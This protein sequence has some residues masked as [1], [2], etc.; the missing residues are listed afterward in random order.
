[1]TTPWT[2]A[3][4]GIYRAVTAAK[5]AMAGVRM[6]VCAF[7][8]VA[9]RGPARVPRTRESLHA[10]PPPF[11]RSIAVAVE[12]FAEY[13]RLYGGHDGPGRLPYAVHTFFDQG[14]RR[15]Y[16]VRIVHDDG[17]QPGLAIASGAM[18]GATAA[19]VPLVA[20]NEGR[21]G[22]LLRAAFGF[23]V[24]PLGAC[25]VEDGGL[26]FRGAESLEPGS[27]LRL[28][29]GGQPVLAFITGVRRG[30]D[31]RLQVTLDRAIDVS[32]PTAELIT[33]IVEIVDG[34]GNRERHD[35]LGLSA[36]H[37]RW[38]ATVLAAASSLVY[39]DASLSG[40]AIAPA[41]AARLPLPPTL[42]PIDA[43]VPQ[44]HGGEDRHAAITTADFFDDAWE[45]GDPERGDG[46]AALAHLD[47]LA[48]VVIPDL[49]VPEPLPSDESVAQ[50]QPPGSPRFLRCEEAPPAVE[51]VRRP[52][53]LDQLYLDPTVDL[54]A[55]VALQTEALAAVE[56]IGDLV[57]L[58]DVPP[59]LTLRQILRWRTH[60][61][62]SFVAA[63]HPWL[64]VAPDDDGRD[65]R[66][67][68]N[69]SAVAAGILARQEL[70]FG[71]PHGPAGVHAAGVIDA[72]EPIGPDA[73]AQLHTVGVNVYL[74]ERGG[75]RLTAG[76]T[77]ADDPSYR[78]LSVRRLMTLLRRTLAIQTQ[79]A[80][81]EPNTP[82]LRRDL[83]G[84]LRAY[85]RQL[86]RAGAFRG[87]HES[88]AFFVRSDAGL[89]TRAD[90]DGGRLIIEVGV[91][92]TEPLEFIVLRL[93]QSNDGMLAVE[94]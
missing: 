91:A 19:P 94:A 23:A 27:L 12:S 72:T 84:T 41:D 5:P 13:R 33:G 64:F 59:R 25:T 86:H 71:V 90:G 11:Q 8:G 45:T 58:L 34:D 20:R 36:D 55:I 4:P 66:I 76:R 17:G 43:E 89:N 46:I 53:E 15:A 93:V 83:A 42:P 7:V 18:T 29:D 16:I 85:L 31:A 80:V 79:W 1:M 82:Q 6:D 69:P 3:A 40:G 22:N 75:I 63:Y 51:A 92:P 44:F 2:S 56:R 74:R 47:D 67:T 38:V 62:S 30:P 68:I 70:A 35:D 88:E 39:P 60:F 37:P 49:Y 87:T 65:R 61:R 9:P 54:A 10:D 50:S 24:K 28:V 21:W 32:D 73:H 57:L 48:T 78:Q 81:F 77:L 26:A 14:G 52:P